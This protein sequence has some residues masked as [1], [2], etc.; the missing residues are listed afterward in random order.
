[1]ASQ[2]D[3]V[4]T[5]ASLREFRQLGGAIAATAPMPPILNIG[6][7]VKLRARYSPEKC[8]VGRGQRLAVNDERDEFGDR[9]VETGDASSCMI[10]GND[11]RL[12]PPSLALNRKGTPE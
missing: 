7:T 6:R 8:S 2:G 11:R 12:P 4:R 5:S 10:D 1:M 3:V 9:D